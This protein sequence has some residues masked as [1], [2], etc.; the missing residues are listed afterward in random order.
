MLTIMTINEPMYQKKMPMLE[1]GLQEWEQLL[2]HSRTT[3]FRV[4]VVAADDVTIYVLHQ[5]CHLQLHPVPPDRA[6][7]E[8][9][10][11]NYAYYGRR[12]RDADRYNRHLLLSHENS[13]K[14]LR[15]GM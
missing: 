9:C 4:V 15:L 11:H 7:H 5:F 12:S 3:T 13:T 1:A 6:S 14:H 10:R 2:A 8:P